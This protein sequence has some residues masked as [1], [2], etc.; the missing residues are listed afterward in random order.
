MADWDICKN[1][2]NRIEEGTDFV[3]TNE[4]IR[5]PSSD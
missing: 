1:Y 5:N 3:K 2:Y 4:I